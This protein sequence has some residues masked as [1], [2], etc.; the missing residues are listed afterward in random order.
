MAVKEKF[1]LLDVVPCYG[2]HI[3]AE[4]KGECIVLAFPRFKNEWVQRFLIPKGI[5]KEL[6]IS[7]EEYGTVVWE[8]ID[9]QRTV[10]EIIGELAEYFQYENGYESRISTFIYQLHKDGFIKFTACK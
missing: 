7:L 1:N 4:R 10:R 9:G 5:S 3:K 2:K 6:H 8:M